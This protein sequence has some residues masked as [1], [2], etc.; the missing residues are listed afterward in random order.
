MRRRR[1]I[2]IVPIAVAGL[3]ALACG[4]WSGGLR[5]NFTRSYPLGLWRIER[6]EREA[7]VGDLVFICPPDTAAFR[8][9]RERGYL[10]R[11]LCPRWSSPL[12]KTVVA[13]EGQTI[14]I[15]AGVLIDGRPLPHSSVQ[16][17][18]AAGR[19][20][21][22]FAGGRIPAGFLFLHSDFAGSYDSRYFGPVPAGGLLG[23]ARPLLTFEP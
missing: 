1:A 4:A 21:T 6:L 19:S 20:L 18:D 15:G 17:N 13:T 8:M 11:G 12:I 22:H 2:V 7:A 10:G 3:V 23:R 9:A 16:P 5:V 14:A